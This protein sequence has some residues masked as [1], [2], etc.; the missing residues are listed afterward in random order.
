MLITAKDVEPCGI[1]RP[2]FPVTLGVKYLNRAFYFDSISW[3]D[4]NAALD[5]YRARVDRPLGPN[6]TCILLTTLN[7]FRLCVSTPE[8]KSFPYEEGLVKICQ[9]MR[10]EVSVQDRSWGLRTF[11][12]VFVGSEAVSWLEQHLRFTR[13]EAVNLGQACLEAGLFTHV[14]EEQG[15]ADEFLFYRFAVDGDPDKR[16]LR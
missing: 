16:A 7:G 12:K 6:E 13:E 1:Q 5:H 9:M 2:G 10:Q 3:T 15:F 11:K 4:E 8:V 14:L